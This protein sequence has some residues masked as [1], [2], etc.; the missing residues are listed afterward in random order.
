M[1]AFVAG[2]KAAGANASQ[3]SFMQA[4]RGVKDF[5][6][7]GLMTPSKID[8]GNFAQFGAGGGPGGCISTA[9]LT[10]EK[11][12]PVEGTPVCGQKLK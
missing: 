1:S 6:A 5:D 10:G 11:F 7:D 9:R 2:L 4:M 3:A 8:F 12:V